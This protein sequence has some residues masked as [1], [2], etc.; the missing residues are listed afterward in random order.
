[1][2]LVDVAQAVTARLAR[3]LRAEHLGDVAGA[4]VGDHHRDEERADTAHAAF[5]HLG[6]CSSKV[7]MPPMPLPM[8]TPTRARLSSVI[9]GR[10]PRRAIL[11]AAT[12]NWTKRSMRLDFFAVQIFFRVEALDLGGDAGRDGGAVEVRHRG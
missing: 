4:H 1:M 8:K 5:Q 10:R 9:P 7:A 3:P 2:E 11:E 12:A 6:C